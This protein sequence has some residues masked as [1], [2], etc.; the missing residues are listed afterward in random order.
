MQTKK[1]V[2][3]E[4]AG[5][6]IADST[7][8]QGSGNGRIDA[9]GKTENNFVFTDLMA[10]CFNRFLCEVAHNP[11]GIGFADLKNEC[12][13]NFTALFSMCDFRVELNSVEASSLISH[14]GNG[15]SRSRAHQFESRRHFSDFVAV[16]HPNLQI[17]LAVFIR[18]VGYILQ[19]FCVA[20]F[21]NFCVAE[22]TLSTVFNLAAELLSHCLHAVAN[23]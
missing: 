21:T 2:I 13:K 14:T 11:V 15:A 20:V 1:T 3:H 10:N 22:L 17:A 7:M 8:N 23:A 19:E 9:A 16:A 6:L 12:L 5:Q 18:K 4:D